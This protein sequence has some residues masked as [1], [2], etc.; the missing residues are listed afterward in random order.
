VRNL[1]Y[2]N[3]YRLILANPFSGKK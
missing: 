1:D 2:L 3:I